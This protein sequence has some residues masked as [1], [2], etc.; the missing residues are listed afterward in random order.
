MLIGIL[1]EY[2]WKS[3]LVVDWAS[4]GYLLQDLGYNWYIGNWPVSFQCID[5]KTIFLEDP[6]PCVFKLAGSNPYWKLLL[7][8][9]QGDLGLHEESLNSIS[10]VELDQDNMFYLGILIVIYPVRWPNLLCIVK[11]SSP[12]SDRFLS[13]SSMI[14]GFWY[15]YL[16]GE[17]RFHK[18]LDV[19]CVWQSFPTVSSIF[20]MAWK[21]AW[22]PWVIFVW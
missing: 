18:C 11:S 17:K 4:K 6:I 9:I 13:Y 3:G 10:Q 12:G 15:V 16:F 2:H 22:L 21:Q 14:F 8:W 20:V 1:S 7:N 19:M 5:I